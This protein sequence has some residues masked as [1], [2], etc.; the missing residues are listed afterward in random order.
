MVTLEQKSDKSFTVILNQVV[1][2]LTLGE[3]I[4]K[5]TQTIR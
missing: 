5:L 1:L 4:L 2:L 3:H